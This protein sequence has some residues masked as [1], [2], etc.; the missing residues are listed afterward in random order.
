MVCLTA[1][2]VAKERLDLSYQGLD[3]PGIPVQVLPVDLNQDGRRDLLIVVAITEWIQEMFEEHSEMEGIEGLVEILT[4]VP[5]LEDR[6]E[7]W[8]YLVDEKGRYTLVGTPIVLP[9]EV[10]AVDIGS[11]SIPAVALADSGVLAVAL[12]E[13]DQIELTPLLDTVSVLTGSGV[14]LPGFDLTVDL[15]G[16]SNLDLVIPTSDGL[17][18]HAG[19][20]RAFE[21]EG[22][23]VPI[24]GDERLGR[25]RWYPLPE[26][27]GVDGD[28]YFDLVWRDPKLG[29][30]IPRVSYGLEGA[31]F[32]SAVEIENRGNEEAEIVFFGDLEGDGVAEV[33][34]RED[35]AGEEDQSFK[36]EMREMES[37][38]FRYR[39]HRASASGEMETEPYASFEA[40][41][42]AFENGDG[43]SIRLPGGFQD[44]G[45]DGRP[46]LVL[47][48]VE[49]SV[50]KALKVMATH[51]MTVPLNFHIWC[52][53]GAGVFKPVRGLDL[54]GK[55]KLN[56][57]DIKIRSL[58]MFEGDFDGDGK[59]DFVQMGRGKKVGIHAGGDNCTFPADPDLVIALEKA[60]PLMEFVK[61][62]DIDADGRS[63]LLVIQPGR[64]NDDVASNPVRLDLYVS[65]AGR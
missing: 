28:R 20:G 51:R 40:V 59:T 62:D 29:W 35:L 43:D 47:M 45:G 55:F 3:L 11:G 27:R 31:T 32:A 50:A 8:A 53:D 33:V 17:S 60:V 19:N 57:N 63:D 58:P 61:I 48:T 52:Q 44:L 1:S 34:T 41:G 65:G 9:P 25:V 15:V 18:I 26:I 16:D 56:L 14:F 21:S 10:L 7:L 6:R 49:F 5:S 64:R 37:P 46:D 2:A 36:E 13:N 42:Y 22:L 12:S 39:F 54:S 24:P 38:P 30:S 4:I 23:L